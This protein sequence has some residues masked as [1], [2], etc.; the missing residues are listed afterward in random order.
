MIGSSAGPAPQPAAAAANGAAIMAMIGAGPAAKASPP[1]PERV[2]AAAASASIAGPPLGA[3]QVDSSAASRAAASRSLQTLLG[4]G[5]AGSGAP[6]RHPGDP[7]TGAVAGAQILGML[8]MAPAPVP[9]PVAGGVSLEIAGEE[10]R[11]VPP[12]EPPSPGSAILSMIR[13][14]NFPAPRPQAQGPPPGAQDRPDASGAGE[15]G[16]ARRLLGASVAATF[17]AKG[18]PAMSLQHFK[19]VRGAGGEAQGRSQGRVYDVSLKF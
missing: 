4:V 17:G 7:A 12:A 10:W 15:G 8:G 19:Q 2:H 16:E 6:P 14:D 3:A 18:C 11:P 1:R 5:P 9:A 13:R